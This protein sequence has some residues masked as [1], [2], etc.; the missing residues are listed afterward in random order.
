MGSSDDRKGSWEF[1]RGPAGSSFCMAWAGNSNPGPAAVTWRQHERG[2]VYLVSCVASL[3]TSLF[4]W[5]SLVGWCC[6]IF[7]FL[8]HMAASLD[9]VRQRAFPVFPRRVAL[10]AAILGMGLT[11]YLPI[12]ALLRFAH[13]TRS[14][15]GTGIGYLVNCLAYRQRDP[16]PGHFI[17]MR[18]SPASSPR[19]GQVVAVAGQEIEWTGRRWRVDGKDL[20]STCPGCC[21]TSPM[22]GGF[23][24]RRTTF[25]SVRKPQAQW[26]KRVLLW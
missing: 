17:W 3:G 7:C 16:V 4:C 10:A 23:R 5:G 11:V 25:S 14:E 12:G 9:V 19:A 24:F 18:L 13:S 2:M 20:Q 6:L 8:T 21:P 1:R 15:G 22:P 26:Q